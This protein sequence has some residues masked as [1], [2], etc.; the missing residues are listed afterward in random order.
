MKA[1]RICERKNGK[2]YTLFHGINGSREMPLGKWIKADVKQVWDGNRKRGA[3]LYTSGFHVFLSPDECTSFIN[4][5]RKPRELVMVEC[6]VQKTHPKSHSPA[7][8][9]LAEKIKLIKVVKVL[10]LVNQIEKL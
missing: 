9:L 3:K 4:R 6:R 8:I 2:L 5:F 7:N 10:P 1:Y